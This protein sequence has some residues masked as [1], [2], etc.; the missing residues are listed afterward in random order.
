MKM[1][2]S[3][4]DEMYETGG[5]IDIPETITTAF[6]NDYDELIINGKFRLIPSENSKRPFYMT[7]SQPL[8]EAYS[9]ELLEAYQKISDTFEDFTQL[10]R[11]RVP[12]ERWPAHCKIDGMDEK[13]F[14][15][16]LSNDWQKN[17]M[18]PVPDYASNVADFLLNRV[19]DMGRIEEK[20]GNIL[21]DPIFDKLSKHNTYWNSSCEKLEELRV[22]FACLNDNLWAIMGIIRRE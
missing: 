15:K 4:R 14:G 22:K 20:L 17:K 21:E 12:Y 18:V 2:K 1:R 10:M 11:K 5:F 7:G 3:R 9:H 16:F 6:I 8:N 13:E 19:Q